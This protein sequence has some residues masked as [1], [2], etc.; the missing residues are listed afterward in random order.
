[1]CFFGELSLELQTNHALQENLSRLQYLAKIWQE[2]NAK[3]QQEGSFQSSFTNVGK[4]V[5]KDN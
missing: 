4:L 5:A 3:A 2:M 1:M